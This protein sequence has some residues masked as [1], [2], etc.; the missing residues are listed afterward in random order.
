MWNFLFARRVTVKWYRGVKFVQGRISNWVSWK[1]RAWKSGWNLSTYTKIGIW[2]QSETRKLELSLLNNKEPMKCLL[3]GVV[4]LDL[5]IELHKVYSSC[6]SPAQLCLSLSSQ[7]PGASWGYQ[8]PPVVRKVSQ[9][10]YLVFSPNSYI[11][12]WPPHAM[13]LGG[14]AF[15]RWVSQGGWSPHEWN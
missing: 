14:G 4:W 5:P 8:L 6:P 7:G 2:V 11:E 3:K 13:I 15:G 10:L 1:D 12:A 9:F